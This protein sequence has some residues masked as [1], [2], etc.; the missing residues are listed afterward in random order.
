MTSAYAIRSPLQLT[1]QAF[2]IS[3]FR[4]V[5][6]ERQQQLE[7]HVASGDYFGTLAT[8]LGLVAD[9]L[10]S[11]DIAFRNRC[12]SILEDACEDLAYLQGNYSIGPKSGDQ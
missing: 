1:G 11:N 7:F 3:V 8:V 9:S 2:G 6:S 5:P 10:A 12:I 4:D